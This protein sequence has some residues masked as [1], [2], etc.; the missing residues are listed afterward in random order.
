VSRTELAS[1]S[2]DTKWE[3]GG[4]TEERRSE[5]LPATATREYAGSDEERRGVRPSI[6]RQKGT[7]ERWRNSES[8]IEEA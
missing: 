4:E 1:H 8:R 2:G 3:R 6:I 5:R 7:E